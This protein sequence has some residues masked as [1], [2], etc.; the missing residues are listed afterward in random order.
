[1]YN[2]HEGPDEGARAA[3]GECGWIKAQPLPRRGELAMG[4]QGVNFRCTIAK[5][6]CVAR[7]GG[8]LTYAEIPLESSSW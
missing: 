3:D 8:S 1:M 5:L 6:A 2:T 4:C 7:G